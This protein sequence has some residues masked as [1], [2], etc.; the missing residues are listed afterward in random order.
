MTIALLTADFS[1]AFAAP[2]V[3]LPP[4]DFNISFALMIAY[5]YGL[6]KARDNGGNSARLS[7]CGLKQPAARGMSRAFCKRFG[8]GRRAGADAGTGGSLRQRKKACFFP[9][10]G[11]Q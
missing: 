11:I 6:C 3:S 10:L 2:S 1:F 7:M 9:V 8:G 5:K 4:Q